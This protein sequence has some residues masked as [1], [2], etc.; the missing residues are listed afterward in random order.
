MFIIRKK[1]LFQKGWMIH[2]RTCDMSCFPC[3]SVFRGHDIC[4]TN[5]MYNI[6]NVHTTTLYAFIKSVPQLPQT[7]PSLSLLTCLWS[8]LSCNTSS[9]RRPF[10][11][12]M[13]FTLCYVKLSLFLHAYPLLW[14]QNLQT[15]Q[16][17]LQDTD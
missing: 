6:D 1:T 15:E 2:A 8:H 10:S 16:T 4:I 14:L 12:I 7:L 9:W 13:L 3:N 17:Q 11:F 5:C